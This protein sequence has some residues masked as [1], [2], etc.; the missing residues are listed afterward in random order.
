MRN[1]VD[2]FHSNRSLKESLR[3]IP[4][5]VVVYIGFYGQFDEKSQEE[6]F[7]AIKKRFKARRVAAYF[8][9]SSIRKGHLFAFVFFPK[10]HLSSEEKLQLQD[11][12]GTVLLQTISKASSKVMK[13][14][15]HKQDV[16]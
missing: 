16:H 15:L 4:N 11:L 9:G 7:F 8:C 5:S 10:T 3:D 13:V 14:R 2:I 6:I 12:V 1:H